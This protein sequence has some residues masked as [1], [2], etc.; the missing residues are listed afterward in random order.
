MVL[1]ATGEIGYYAEVV[2][3]A[4]DASIRLRLVDGYWD[5][6][7]SAEAVK[8]VAQQLRSGLGRRGWQVK[9]IKPA[10]IRDGIVYTY[11]VRAPEEK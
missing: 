5:R 6:V 1:V 3:A 11:V 9:G 10:R 7:P 2:D 8:P 4:P